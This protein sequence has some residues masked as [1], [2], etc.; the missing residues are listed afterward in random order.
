VLKG[1][2]GVTLIRHD[3]AIVFVLGV[4]RLTRSEYCSASVNLGRGLMSEFKVH[5]RADKTHDVGSRIEDKRRRFFA[6]KEK[7][8]PCTQGYVLDRNGRGV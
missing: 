8:V 6:T 5:I 7:K 3:E 1:Q 4:S 2:E